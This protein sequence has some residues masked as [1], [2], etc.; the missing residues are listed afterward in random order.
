MTDD[1]EKS[2]AQKRREK[3]LSNSVTAADAND[4]AEVEKVAASVLSPREKSEAER[5]A[6]TA[7]AYLKREYGVNAKKYDNEI[8]LLDAVSKARREG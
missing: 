4:P 7:T 8:D 2:I 5:T 3:R 1:S 6:G